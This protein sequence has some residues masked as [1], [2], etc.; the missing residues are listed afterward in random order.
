MKRKMRKELSL[1]LLCYSIALILKHLV[2]MPEIIFGILMGLSLSLEI[3]G[4]LPEKAY[5]S[6]KEWKKRKPDSQ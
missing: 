6:L 3:V 4:V 2:P 5:N 1:G